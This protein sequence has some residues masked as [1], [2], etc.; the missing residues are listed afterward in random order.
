MPTERA[1]VNQE[2]G[3]IIEVERESLSVSPVYIQETVKSIA[4][5][6]EMTRS[7]L[8]RGR[9]YGRTPG[10]P[11]EGLWD[12]GASLLIGGFNCYVGQRRVLQLVDEE[13]KISVVLEVPIIMRQSGREVG[14]GI[15]AASTNEVKYKY[16]WFFPSE[17]EQA[18]YTKEQIASLKTDK[19]HPGKHRVD[20]MERGELLNTLVKQASK[21]AEVDAAE[22]LPGVASVLREMFDP[23]KPAEGQGDWSQSDRT[24]SPPE[25]AEAEDWTPF[26]GE[27]RAL[28]L[29]PQQAHE[30]LK[31]KSMKEWLTNNPGKSRND[32]IK[33][34]STMVGKKGKRNP[35]TIKTFEAL[36]KACAE[37]W[38]GQFKEPGT[39]EK[40]VMEM[41][42]STEIDLVNT[43]SEIYRVIAEARGE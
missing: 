27:I 14:S 33:L 38:P 16:R 8:K 21:R 23:R 2:T 22:A 3:E 5:L 34:L 10:T 41:G 40:V 39:I 4:L 35:D 19:K 15:G 43:P 36:Y 30:M 42:G 29:T 25:D 9:D 26:W 18:G 7:L 32:I 6:Q 28:G 13:D 31:V 20:N 1:L 11:Q 37:D 17:L 24:K 12:P